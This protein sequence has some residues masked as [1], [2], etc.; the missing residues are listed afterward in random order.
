LAYRT[1]ERKAKADDVGRGVLKTKVFKTFPQIFRRIFKKNL[2]K[3]SPFQVK[4]D[5]AICHFV[6]DGRNYPSQTKL[7]EE[8]IKQKIEFSKKI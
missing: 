1:T 4:I 8:I 2:A 3:A 7:L 5:L 6:S